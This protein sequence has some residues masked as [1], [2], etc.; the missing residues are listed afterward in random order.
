[1]LLQALGFTVFLSAPFALKILGLEALGGC[2]A[3]LSP[4]DT[5]GGI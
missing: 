2:H 3:D 1:M 5:L 4:E